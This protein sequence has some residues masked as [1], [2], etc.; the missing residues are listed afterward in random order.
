MECISSDVK[1]R[2]ICV[3]IKKHVKENEWKERLE[4]IVNR[5][6]YISKL[7]SLLFNLHIRRLLEEN[8]EIPSFTMPLGEKF[9]QMVTQPCT[10][11]KKATI[12]PEIQETFEKYMQNKFELPTR[13]KIPQNVIQSAAREM[14]TNFHTN[15]KTHLWK[16]LRKH[17]ELELGTK[18]AASQKMEEILEQNKSY[19][20]L[21]KNWNS[22]KPEEFLPL[23]WKML[24]KRK[25][26]I[27]QE[28]LEEEQQKHLPQEKQ[29]KV[30]KTRLFSLAPLK[31]GNIPGSIHIDTVSL[32]EIFSDLFTTCGINRKNHKAYEKEIW[33]EIFE[34]PKS[35]KLHFQYYCTT[36]G[37]SI[38][39]LY[40]S[41]EKP[42]TGTK[43]RK[44]NTT[45]SK[46]Q[47]VSDIPNLENLPNGT[48]VGLD[49]G[50]KT[51]LYMTSYDENTG[52]TKVVKYTAMQRRKEC[53]FLHKQQIIQ[54]KKKKD[55]S[56]QELENLL[57][58]YDSREPQLEYFQQYVQVVLQIM[59]KLHSFYSRIYF[60]ILKR[61]TYIKTQKSEHALINR[62]SNTFGKDCVI[63][64]GSWTSSTQMKNLMPTPTCR[65]K[66][67]LSENFTVVTVPE[68]GTT[69][70]CHRLSF[71]FY[72]GSNYFILNLSQVWR[73]S[74]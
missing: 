36:D 15:I 22:A 14:I 20:L 48:R 27:E 4:D 17:L 70:T 39:F 8:L 44:R 66:K 13:S 68:W 71:F 69:Q 6:H 45:K 46:R 59:E 21:P 5:M 43:K 18:E 64:Y 72:S 56:I 62:I 40:S 3:S 61:K 16:R 1:N 12:P 41:K 19:D 55:A 33:E 35:K 24:K 38:G 37:V 47:Q 60:R 11:G 9:F 10:R 31:R 30:R 7:S 42:S 23:M 34:I 57:S 26:K 2:T 28:K 52:E 51:I 53:F 67:K 63:G 50:K 73:K 25:E 74:C 49:P 54:Q 32:C 29:K 58:K 65:I